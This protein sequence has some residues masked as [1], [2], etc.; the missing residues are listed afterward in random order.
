MAD[1]KTLTMNGKTYNIKDSRVDGIDSRV[2]DLES[3]IK[4]P[5]TFQAVTVG[6][7]SWNVVKIDLG[8]GRAFCQCW[9]AGIALAA[10]TYAAWGSTSAGS[11]IQ[12]FYHDYTNAAAFP[13]TF[14]YIPTC[15]VQSANSQSM[16]WSF[17][18]TTPTN[19]GTVRMIGQSTA[20]RTSAS[21]WTTA[22]P[23][24]TS[25]ARIS[26]G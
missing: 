5:I 7:T 13:V 8:D 23:A 10:S 4:G 3:Y 24:P 18:S 11:S 25:T 19:L 2:D 16:V 14:K 20:S 15:R 1:M 9:S 21:T 22:I 17:W 6:S 26:S 12:M